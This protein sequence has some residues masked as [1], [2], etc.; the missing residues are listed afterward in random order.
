[1]AR[2][3]AELL[4]SEQNRVLHMV[5]ADD[6]LDGILHEIIGFADA[7]IPYGASCVML[8]NEQA[9]HFTSVLSKRYP[10]RLLRA[11]QGMP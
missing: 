4:Q 2:K 5:M 8:V 9:S 10:P 1:S 7:Q 6:D 11:L 3:R